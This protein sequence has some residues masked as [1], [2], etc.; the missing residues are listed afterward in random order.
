MLHHRAYG[1]GVAALDVV[2]VDDAKPMQSIL[3]SI[4]LNA[5]VARV[6]TFDGAEPA[7]QAMLVE[8][9]HLLITDWNM[10][11]TDGLTLVRSMRRRRM[12]Q[13]A[14]VPAIMIT[15]HPTRGLVEEALQV[16]THFVI[17]KPV[18]PATLMKRIDFVLKDA[19]GFSLLDDEKTVVLEGQTERVAD[20]RKRWASS[21]AQQ[22][23][24]L[25]AAAK[26]FRE[27]AAGKAEP[28]KIEAPAGEPDELVLDPASI[29]PSMRDLEATNTGLRDQAT[30]LGG[31]APVGG[32]KPVA[33]PAKPTAGLGGAPGQPARSGA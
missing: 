29:K 19:R 8:P 16:G 17:A 26:G 12:G 4:L 25:G 28:A 14:L 11:P 30:R 15:A 7:M 24:R 22:A 23:L 5:H 1:I 9:P 20:E 21:Y 32:R 6:R 2:V 3:R 27:A 31:F 33:T 18:S 13:V 10:H